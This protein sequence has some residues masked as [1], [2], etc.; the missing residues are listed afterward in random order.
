MFIYLLQVMLVSMIP[1]YVGDILSL[2]LMSWLYSYY[3]FEYKIFALKL[4]TVESIQIFESNWAYYFGF[5]FF[6]SILLYIN[7]GLVSS[8]VF[9]LAFPFLVLTSVEASPPSNEKLIEKLKTKTKRSL[10]VFSKDIRQEFTDTYLLRKMLKQKDTGLIPSRINMFYI[11]Q[12]IYSF[13]ILRLQS[14]TKIE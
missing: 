12:K 14:F 5:G 7:P 1:F 4:N 9:A 2:V 10:A 8:G 11:P 13:L 3:C 6:F